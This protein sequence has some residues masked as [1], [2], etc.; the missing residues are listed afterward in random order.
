ML[1]VTRGAAQTGLGYGALLHG[2]AVAIGTHMAADL[3]FRLGWIQQ[4]VKDRAVSLMRRA[5]LP[6]ELP[7]GG[8]MDM[9]KFLDV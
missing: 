8:G 6:V 9:D 4:D 7:K 3:S 1:H 5:N 2:E